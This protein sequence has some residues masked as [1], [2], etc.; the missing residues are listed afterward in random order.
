MTRRQAGFLKTQLDMYLSLHEHLID[1]SIAADFAS[2]N[3]AV[4]VYY[5][6][7]THYFGK[8]EEVLEE[9]AKHASKSIQRS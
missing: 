4:S 1:N 6:Q 7:S 9:I 5:M 3:K 8:S 2:G